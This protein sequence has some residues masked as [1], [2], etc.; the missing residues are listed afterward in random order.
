MI[1]RD[2]VVSRLFMREGV[3]AMLW[4]FP[5]PTV[6]AHD[7]QLNMSSVTKDVIDHQI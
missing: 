1:E 7:W 6:T 4:V 5:P 3:N 2:R